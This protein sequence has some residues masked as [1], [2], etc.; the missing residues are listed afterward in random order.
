M[1]F[2][3]KL[4]KVFNLSL[5]G[6]MYRLEGGKVRANERIE[7]VYYKFEK[8]TI[9][10]YYKYLLIIIGSIPIAFLLFSAIET[11]IFDMQ[12]KKFNTLLTIFLLYVYL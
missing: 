3:N 1:N 11:H 9:E 5:K 12:L 4:P 2:L 7:I 6:Q 10:K 8:K